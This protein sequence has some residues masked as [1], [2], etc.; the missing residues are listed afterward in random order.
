MNKSIRQTAN[1]LSQGE[2]GQTASLAPHVE[3]TITHKKQLDP[4]IRHNRPTFA[5]IMDLLGL[6]NTVINAPAQFV[7]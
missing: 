4:A 7:Q 6:Q 2:A 5:E 1:G 3:I